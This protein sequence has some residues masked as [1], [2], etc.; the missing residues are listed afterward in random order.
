MTKTTNLSNNTICLMLFIY[1][2]VYIKYKFVNS[3]LYSA[4]AALQNLGL[5]AVLDRKVWRIN[6]INF[7]SLIHCRPG[8]VFIVYNAGSQFKSVG[9]GTIQPGRRKKYAGKLQFCN[10]YLIVM[11][12][13]KMNANQVYWNVFIS[14]TFLYKHKFYTEA[15]LIFE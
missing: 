4:K 5:D 9:T 2:Y 11:F 7:F 3:S 10:K 15:R 1:V 14:S 12:N 8:E 6:I 13:L